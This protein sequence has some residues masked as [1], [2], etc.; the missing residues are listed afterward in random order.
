VLREVLPDPEYTDART[1]VQD[2]LVRRA[3]TIAEREKF[4][5]AE[6][7]ALFANG[8]PVIRVM[9]LGLMGGDPSLV[10][11]GIARRGHRQ[12]GHAYRAVRGLAPYRAAVGTLL[13]A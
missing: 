5:A 7:R 10:E 12:A 3:G 13:G 11:C 6:I 1:Y 9:V 8:T 2:M 4:D